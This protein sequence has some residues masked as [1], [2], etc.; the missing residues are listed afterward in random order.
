M[1]AHPFFWPFQSCGPYSSASIEVKTGS[2][3]PADFAKT[4]HLLPLLWH[5]ELRRLRYAKIAQT[6]PQTANIRHL[7]FGANC[8]KSVIRYLNRKKGPLPLV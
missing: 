7:V 4:Q 6:M 5:I 8:H 2:P 3:D 1:V